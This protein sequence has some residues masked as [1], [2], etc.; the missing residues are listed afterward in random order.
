MLAHYGGCSCEIH[1]QGSA[2][3]LVY[4]HAKIAQSSRAVSLTHPGKTTEASVLLHSTP[5]LSLSQA[6]LSSL[7]NVFLNL[8]LNT[9]RVASFKIP[10]AHSVGCFWYYVSSV[11]GGK[12]LE[13]W[14]RQNEDGWASPLASQVPET[15]NWSC[16]WR[17]CISPLCDW[18]YFQHYVSC[19]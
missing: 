10:N 11:S 16:V 8:F 15:G 14:L 2:C 1:I 4:A 9:L 3:V 5:K 19:F 6:I 7:V 17:Y 12:V 18:L 13:N